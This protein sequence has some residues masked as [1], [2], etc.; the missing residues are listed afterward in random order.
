MS[1]IYKKM[2]DE[3]MA[4]QQA[5]V[6]VIKVKRGG[7]FVISD[8]KP[9]LD[10]VNGMTVGE[11]QSPEIIAL[12]KDSVNAQYDILSAL[13]KTITPEDDPFVE[14]NQTGPILELLYEMDP[15]F[16]EAALKFAQ[17]I[18]DNEALIGL[19][20]IRR[21]G[22]FYGPTAVVDFAFVPG[23]TTNVVNNILKDL[24]IDKHYKQAIL[25]AKSWGMNSSYG[26]GGVF[27]GAIENGATPDEAVKAE[28]ATLRSL[29]ETPMAAQAEQ[30][31]DHTSFDTAEYMKRYKEAIKP[32]VDAAVKAKVHYG[33]IVTVPA[34][35][36][37]DIGHHIALSMFNMAKDDVVMAVI[38]S[39]SQVMDRTL[40]KGLETDAYESVFDVLSTATG[41]TAT[42]VAYLLEREG[43]AIPTVIDLLTKRFFNYLQLNPT[44]SGAVELHNVDFMDMIHRGAKIL[45]KAHK[46]HSGEPKVKGIPVALDAIEES[47]ILSNTQRY[48]YAVCASTVAFSALMRLSDFPCLLTSEPVTATMMTNVIALSPDKPGAPARA[49]KDC[50][51]TTLIK[52]CQ[53]CNCG[54]SV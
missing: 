29:Y 49:C 38:E 23:S 24:D 21:Y 18:A 12:H 10:A 53:Y 2:I 15:A 51:V 47:E 44:R 36:V 30:M 17:A 8:A 45:D 48:T 52:R 16:K 35:C 11:G 14:H 5:D 19:E 50:A 39:V 9:Y 40:R 33:N 34:Y 13:T 7:P 42:A 43:F 26:I 25:A 22:G 46:K 37:G 28:I 20:S 27:G 6:D 4:A 31:K 41:S 3:A 1:S 32:A 54:S